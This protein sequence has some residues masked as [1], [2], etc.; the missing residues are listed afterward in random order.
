MGYHLLDPEELDRWDD[1]QS[2]PL[3]GVLQSHVEFA[4]PFSDVGVT[5]LVVEWRDSILHDAVCRLQRVG[6]GFAVAL[7]VEQKRRTAVLGA[8]A[9]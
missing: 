3:E 7:D 5:R 6:V 1:E 4:G 9:V 2:R 8:V